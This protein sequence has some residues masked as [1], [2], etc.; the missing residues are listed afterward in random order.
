MIDQKDHLVVM[1]RKFQVDEKHEARRNHQKR[2][3]NHHLLKFMN[4]QR[5]NAVKRKQ[6]YLK[7]NYKN[8][9]MKFT[10]KLYNSKIT[11]DL[12]RHS[13]LTYHRNKSIQTIINS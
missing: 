1:M 13:S 9:Y 5:R 10:L 6:E 2:N 4:H 7:L 11:K 12:L 8:N 3:E